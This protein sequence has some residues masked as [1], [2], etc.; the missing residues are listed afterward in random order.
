[1]KHDH[2]ASGTVIISIDL[3]LAWGNG[4]KKHFV[5]LHQKEREAINAF[6]ALCEKYD[7]PC[8]WATVGNLFLKDTQEAKNR[9]IVLSEK[10][11][12]IY[13]LINDSNRSLW[14]GSDIIEQILAC[15]ASQ[16]IGC[17]TMFHTLAPEVSTDAFR[18]ELTQ[19]VML[20]KEKYDI[21]MRSFVYGRNYVA[22]Q[23]ILTE[24]GFTSFRGHH[25]AH[26]FPGSFGE[27]KVARY[28]ESLIPLRVPGV[29]P[30]KHSD[31]IVELP[32]SY[33]LAIM[34]AKTVSVPMWLRSMRCKNGVRGSIRDNG[35]FH[36]W[37]HPHNL[38]QNIP[39]WMH[40]LEDLFQYLAKER[41]AQNIEVHTMGSYTEGYLKHI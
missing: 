18:T 8:T 13:E 35:I 12:Q 29:H 4:G 7:I 40:T 11:K 37:F 17:H 15:K 26:S 27:T 33:F 38:A 5:P 14:F 6:L 3:E 22:H 31:G 25:V 16:E 32:A 10:A 30:L 9:G 2:C 36:M 1:M 41:D 39:V 28:L 34:L 24:T 20:A 23:E 21:I 19:A